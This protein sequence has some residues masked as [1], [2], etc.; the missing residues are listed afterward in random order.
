M[1]KFYYFMLDC[2]YTLEVGACS[3]FKKTITLFKQLKNFFFSR[4]ELSFKQETLFHVGIKTDR[5]V[6]M[7]Y[8][9]MVGAV[10]RGS[11]DFEIE[12]IK[13]DRTTI[14]EKI[15]FSHM[16]LP[17]KTFYGPIHMCVGD[18]LKLIYGKHINFEIG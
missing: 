17:T 11:F 9:Y 8:S 15:T 2:G 18:V 16:S 4:Y 1:W 5:D 3:L 12:P 6:V 13:W 7:K 14:V 10:R